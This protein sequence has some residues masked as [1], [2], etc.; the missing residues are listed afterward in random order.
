M[1]TT[2]LTDRLSSACDRSAKFQ[3]LHELPFNY[4]STEY[5][6]PFNLAV[7]AHLTKTR[8]TGKS[9]ILKLIR[10]KR[11]GGRGRVIFAHY[12]T[13]DGKRFA[14][15]LSPKAFKGYEWFDKYGTT[16][17]LETGATYQVSEDRCSCKDWYHRVRTGKK[18]YCKHQELRAKA[19]GINIEDTLNARQSKPSDRTNNDRTTDTRSPVTKTAA[20]TPIAPKHPTTANFEKLDKPLP[21]NPANRYKINPNILD[22]G[23]SLKRSDD[24]TCTEWYFY[25]WHKTNPFSE[26][27]QKKI[28]RI[29]ET[30]RGFMAAGVQGNAREIVSYQADAVGWILRYNGFSYAAI[31][32]AYKESQLPRI[33]PKAEVTSSEAKSAAKK[34]P[35]ILRTTPPDVVEANG[36]FF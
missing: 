2:N 24:H 17:N 3:K 25:A 14:T 7:I 27:V 19:L 22:P 29:I 6:D 16:V 8:G 34:Y 18:S 20:P 35:K 36:G 28:G 33:K 23:L 4:R 26:P 10:Y 32:S 30:D 13:V 9:A 5:D 31:E 21:Y 11:N 12:E 1:L 15:F